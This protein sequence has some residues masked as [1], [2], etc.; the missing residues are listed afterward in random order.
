MKKISVC[1]FLLLIII[2]LITCG[3]TKNDKLS[4]ILPDNIP[5]YSRVENSSEVLT[6]NNKEPE[7]QLPDS[8]DNNVELV[9][10]CE[11][12]E[13]PRGLLIQM[14][15]DFNDNHKLINVRL[16]FSQDIKRLHLNPFSVSDNVF[17]GY[18]DILIGGTEKLYDW[19]DMN[20]IKPVN[21]FNADFEKFFG[22]TFINV[23][24][25][26][27]IYGVPFFSHKIQLLYYNKN[28][29]KELPSSLEETSNISTDELP[30]DFTH[31]NYPFDVPLYDIPFLY[32]NGFGGIGSSADMVDSVNEAI[33]DIRAFQDT[34]PVNKE[35]ITYETAD[36][37]FREGKSAFMI[38]GDWM[39]RSYKDSLGESLGITFIPSILNGRITPSYF[40]ELKYFFIS[41][42]IK[43]GEKL[44]AIKTFL[45]YMTNSKIQ[46]YLMKNSIFT[47]PN[48]SMLTSTDI[49][50]EELSRIESFSKS[51]VF[52]NEEYKTTVFRIIERYVIPLIKSENKI[53]TLDMIKK[54]DLEKIKAYIVD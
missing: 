7:P 11:I 38:N 31:F 13:I 20:Y 14:V 53:L 43:D 40:A 5:N 39:M 46:S 49:S 52:Y 10:I 1:F 27:D 19:V 12:S 8:L 34:L 51:I 30:I 29:V 32:D 42:L 3:S 2:S 4:G 44:L 54:R 36:Y 41:S 33:E 25:G 26:G 18:A 37:L 47:T 16:L 35:T 6:K 50:H 17:D 48:K 15:E 24:M 9:L 23:Y 28:F 21:S 45:D 22:N